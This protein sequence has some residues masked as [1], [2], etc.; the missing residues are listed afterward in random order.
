M[1][2]SMRNEVMPLEIF[3]SRILGM[4]YVERI[5][6]LLQL[7]VNVADTAGE[8]LAIEVC[9]ACEWNAFLNSEVR[10]PSH[11]VSLVKSTVLK[12]SVEVRQAEMHD[13]S[14][15]LNV[16]GVIRRNCGIYVGR[17]IYK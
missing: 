1:S 5:K 12:I 13:L 6:D 16:G 10:H 14:N 15:V 9:S 3:A 17:S 2:L 7:E 8:W 4:L 11:G